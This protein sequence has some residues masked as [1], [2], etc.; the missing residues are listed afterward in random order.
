MC[1]YRYYPP[2]GYLIYMSDLHEIKYACDLL[3]IVDP[4]HGYINEY[5]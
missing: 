3:W 1:M 5:H 2:D 4:E